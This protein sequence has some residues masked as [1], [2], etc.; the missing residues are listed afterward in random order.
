ML[1]RLSHQLHAVL[2]PRSAALVL[3]RGWFRTTRQLVV[4]QSWEEAVRPEAFMP[5]AL[6]ELLDAAGLR[7]MPVRI[8][9][10]DALVRTWRVQPPGNASRAQDIE[11]AA[12]MRFAAVF[13][14]PADDWQ[15]AAAPRAADAFLACAVRRTLVDG[16]RGV[17]AVR[18][19]HL[20]V[21]EPEFAAMWNHWRLSMQAGSWLGIVR[22][23]SL[24]LGI[25]RS[26]ALNAVQELARP[27]TSDPAW[28]ADVV[29]READRLD[30]PVPRTL[31][32]CGVPPATWLSTSLACTLLGPQC[33]ALSLLGGAA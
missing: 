25:V 20:T 14:E 7:A 15:I 12:A 11:A 32:L 1:D 26:S 16:L 22:P 29:R 6:A 3:Q 33:D 23:T 18:G 9:L 21:M 13:D 17:L 4:R 31:A 30:L 24:A 19:L 5:Q 8:V 2:G 27:A 10:A 28:L